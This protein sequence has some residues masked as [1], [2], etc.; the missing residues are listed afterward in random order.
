M[1][2]GSQIVVR[3][4]YYTFFFGASGRGNWA[5]RM[6]PGSKGRVMSEA[7]PDREWVPEKKLTRTSKNRWQASKTGKRARRVTRRIPRRICRLRNE[8]PR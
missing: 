4:G 8:V 7:W 3:N 2:G 1:E 5:E 6:V